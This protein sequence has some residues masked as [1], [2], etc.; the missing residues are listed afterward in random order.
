MTNGIV[1]NQGCRSNR[2]G[3]TTAEDTTLEMSSRVH[4]RLLMTSHFTGGDFNYYHCN[5]RLR[6]NVWLEQNLEMCLSLDASEEI[7]FESHFKPPANV[8][9]CVVFSVL[10]FLKNLD[11]Q[12]EDLVWQSERSLIEESVLTSLAKEN[13]MTSVATR[14][15]AEARDTRKRFWGALRARLV[16]TATTTSTFPTTVPRMMTETTS[17]M[18]TDATCEWGGR[19]GDLGEEEDVWLTFSKE[20]FGGNVLGI[21]AITDVNTSDKSILVKSLTLRSPLFSLPPVLHCRQ[22]V[23]RAAREKITQSTRMRKKPEK[24]SAKTLK[25]AS[26]VA[27]ETV[28]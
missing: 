16:N 8:D 1:I 28:Q 5:S 3:I 12:K 14:M 2:R 27:E 13:G 15:S 11:V 23:F 10:R 21:V 24:E 7:G 26:L 22:S 9:R 18:N 17:T 20:E 25:A 19:G 4:W 6:D